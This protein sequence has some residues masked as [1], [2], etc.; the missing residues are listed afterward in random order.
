MKV[1]DLIAAI[2]DGEPPLR[3]SAYD[4]SSVRP[5]RC[6]D[7]AAPD[8]RA[9]AALPAHRARRP[10]D[11]PGL[12]GRRPRGDRRAS[13]R[14]VRG[15]A[16]VRGVAAAPAAGRPRSPACCAI[17]AGAGCCRP[18]RRRE[19]APP[20][21]RRTAARAAP[22]AQ[23]RRRPRSARTTTCRTPSTSRCSARPWPTPARC[24]PSP[25]RRSSRRRRRSSTSSPRK[26]G[27]R[28]GMRLLDVGCGWGGMAIHAAK[29]YGVDVVAVTLS[30]E[31]A[32]WGQRAV[33]R[34]GLGDQVRILHSDYRDSPGDGL[35]RGQLDRPDRAHRRRQLPVLLQLP[36]RQAARRRP[37]AQPLH[38]PADQ[39]RERA[40]RASSSTAT[41]SPTAS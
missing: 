10:R 1:A 14:P 2:T 12:R 24:S 30:R 15:A 41:S 34:E 28:P 31:Q 38:H 23:P 29:H 3:F 36:V 16:A 6:A 25:T 20:R 4:G 11:G 9:R 32:E 7:R 18:I 27:L 8:E 39:H 33:E 17:S 13:R 37:A 21:W 26:L 22:L 40:C 35:R 19:E 5:G